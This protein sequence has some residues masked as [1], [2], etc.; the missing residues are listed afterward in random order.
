[1]SDFKQ[2]GYPN[3]ETTEGAWQRGLYFNEEYSELLNE[4]NATPD[5]EGRAEVYQDVNEKFIEDAVFITTVF[6]LNPKALGE[7]VSG[8]GTQGG[9]SNFHYASL[10]G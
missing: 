1:M 7:G 5:L 8:V 10:D 9:L 6:P 4:A 2:F 3:E